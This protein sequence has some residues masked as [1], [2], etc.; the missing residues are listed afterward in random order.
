MRVSQFTPAEPLPLP[1]LPEQWFSY[2][3]TITAETGTITTTSA[4]QGQYVK[5]G[6]VVFFHAAFT[7][8]NNGTGADSLLAS[9]PVSAAV[10]PGTILTGRRISGATHEG[11]YGYVGTG[12]STCSIYKYNGTYPGGNSTSLWVSG[13]YRAS[14]K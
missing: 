8:D 7:I 10:S 5:L 13:F 6:M 9:L 2:T 12:S 11:C 14:T 4:V 3:P 1:F